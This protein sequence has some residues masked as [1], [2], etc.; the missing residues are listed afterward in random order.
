MRPETQATLRQLEDAHWFS[1][2]GVRDAT[3][4]VAVV[5]SSWDEAIEF[6][7]SLSWENMRLEIANSFRKKLL[8]K[9]MV[10]YRQ[11][12][13]IVDDV[14]TLTMPLVERKIGP[15]VKRFGLPQVFKDDVHWDILHLCMEAE[16][17]DV[18]PPGFYSGLAFWYANGHFPCGWLEDEPRGR[19]I[20]Y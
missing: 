20:I 5:L 3:S 1:S 10:R 12:N 4:S 17:V 18:C 7:S 16:Y 14:K 15:V 11:W 8:E 6:S 9:A 13:D 2:V 19:P